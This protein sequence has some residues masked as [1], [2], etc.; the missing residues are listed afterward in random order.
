MLPCVSATGPS[1]GALANGALGRRG[2][3]SL[4]VLKNLSLEKLS[5]LNKG[6]QL[7]RGE[8]RSQPST[9]SKLLVTSLLSL[10]GINSQEFILRKND[11]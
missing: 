10:G 7:R 5:D 1:T 2:A 8:A 6:A 4:S 11:R 9:S 3:V